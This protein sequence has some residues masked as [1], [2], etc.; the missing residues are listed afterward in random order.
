MKE[1]KI[2]RLE[3]DI[4]NAF[5]GTKIVRNVIKGI[6]SLFSNWFFIGY[7]EL[8]DHFEVSF[9]VDIN[10]TKVAVFMK[11]L[12][13]KG[14]NLKIWH[15]HYVSFDENKKPQLHWGAEA[16]ELFIGNMEKTFLTKFA[17]DITQQALLLQ[18]EPVGGKQ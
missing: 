12:L 16:Q 6:P 1:E 2:D 8:R 3:N 4:L 11:V 9:N 18:A 5:P 14:Y 10:P 13:S 15:E 7:N 17:T